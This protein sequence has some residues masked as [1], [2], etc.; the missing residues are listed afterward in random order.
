MRSKRK[1]MKLEKFGISVLNPVAESEGSASVDLNSP[2]M[3]RSSARIRKGVK[4]VRVFFTDPDVTDSS[5]EEE[6]ANHGDGS[7]KR[8]RVTFVI[9][10]GAPAAT[11]KP[12]NLSKPMMTSA[13]MKQKGIRQRQW[14]KWA[15]EIR[16]PIRGVR[17]WLGTFPT[18]E[19]AAEAYRL[20]AMRIEE[21]KTAMLREHLDSNDA[22]SVDR[23]ISSSSSATVVEVLKAPVSP[24]SIL[25]ISSAEDSASA[26]AAAVMAAEEWFGDMATPTEV[27]F[28]LDEEPFLVGELDE[29]CIGLADLPMWENQLDGG[30]FSFL[31][32]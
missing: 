26:G 19:E 22:S 3:L 17:L 4:E 13:S 20:A 23:S 29:D 6:D 1:M 21:Q 2:R 24:S 8:R 11:R 12:P 18:A 14:G 9:P 31:D 30:D 10:L 15:A 32:L 7:E 28:G 27:E 16:D 5:S 25:D